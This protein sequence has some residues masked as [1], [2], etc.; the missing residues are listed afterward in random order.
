MVRSRSENFSKISFFQS[1][2]SFIVYYTVEVSTAPMQ[3]GSVMGNMILVS[4]FMEEGT[5]TQ[6]H[7]NKY[8]YMYVHT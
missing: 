4:A 8:A 3:K 7:S 5:I 6:G 1:F 2:F